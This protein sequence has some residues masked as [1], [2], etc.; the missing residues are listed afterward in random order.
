MTAPTTRAEAKAAGIL[1]RAKQVPWYLVRRWVYG[2]LIAAGAL[3]TFYGIIPVEA[4]PLWI[5]LGLALL[6]TKPP[7]TPD[8]G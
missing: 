5:A 4:V 8:E 2:V 1:T 7:A 6:N 3:A